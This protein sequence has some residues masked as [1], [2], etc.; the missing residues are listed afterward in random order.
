MVMNQN[1]EA[2]K[3]SENEWNFLIFLL[4]YNDLDLNNQKILC[5]PSVWEETGFL[6]H[7]IWHLLIKSQIKWKVVL[8]FVAFLK[9]WTFRSM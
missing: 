8:Y 3:Q 1:F 5:L 4:F 7:P 9:T 6:N 2:D